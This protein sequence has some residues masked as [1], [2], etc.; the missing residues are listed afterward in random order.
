MTAAI[1][2]GAVFSPISTAMSTSE[3]RVP[4]SLVVATAALAGA[5][6]LVLGGNLSKRVRRIVDPAWEEGGL[7]KSGSVS[8]DL[9]TTTRGS[10]SSTGSGSGSGSKRTR[11]KIGLKAKFRGSGEVEYRERKESP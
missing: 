2:G 7:G 3:S 5:W 10:E 9:P 4:L 6:V 8:E 11:L 1:S